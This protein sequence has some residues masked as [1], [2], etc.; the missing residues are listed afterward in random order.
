MLSYPLS[1]SKMDREPTQ[2]RKKR[3]ETHSH[4]RYGEAN[5]QTCIYRAVAFLP[6]RLTIPVPKLIQSLPLRA[7]L[8]LFPGIPC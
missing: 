3:K 8:L 5:I 7:F 2:Y 1:L 4:T 6:P